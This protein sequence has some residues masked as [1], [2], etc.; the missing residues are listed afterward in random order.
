M[1]AS[2]HD[3]YKSCFDNCCAV[4][5]FYISPYLLGSHYERVGGVVIGAFSPSRNS[6]LIPALQQEM[7]KFDRM[8]DRANREIYNPAGL[9]L[10]SPR[11][12]AYLFVS[13]VET[14]L[15]RRGLARRGAD[16]LAAV[17]RAAGD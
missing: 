3:P 12:N 7:A 15:A 17:I 13:R 11:R 16:C 14:L 2:A 1:L 8:M 4:L 10:L 9:N 5:T 6:L